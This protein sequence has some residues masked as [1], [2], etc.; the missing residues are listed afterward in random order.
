MWM[1]CQLFF[2]LGGG[3]G[4]TVVGNRVQKVFVLCSFFLLLTHNFFFLRNLGV[5]LV[6]PGSGRLVWWAAAEA[7]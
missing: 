2:G 6:G 3:A 4:F 5:F 7:W 1:Y